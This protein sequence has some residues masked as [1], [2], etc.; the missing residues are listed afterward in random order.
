M[1]FTLEFSAFKVNTLFHDLCQNQQVHS[2]EN[3]NERLRV[4]VFWQ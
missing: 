4:G 1:D 3:A 2:K